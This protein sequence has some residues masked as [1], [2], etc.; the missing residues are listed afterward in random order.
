[1]VRLKHYE[2]RDLSPIIGRVVEIRKSNGARMFC[3]RL[4]LKASEGAIYFETGG[5][6]FD[7]DAVLAIHS[8][9]NLIPVLVLI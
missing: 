3:E 6:M 9:Q 4:S 8:A 2:D 5:I 1:M 7:A